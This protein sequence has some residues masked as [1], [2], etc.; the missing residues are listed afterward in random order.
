MK[1]NHIVVPYNNMSPGI[2]FQIFN[3]FFD[4]LLNGRAN[5]VVETWRLGTEPRLLIN[6]PLDDFLSR[7]KFREPNHWL[8]K[9]LALGILS[10]FDVSVEAE[11]Q[12][13]DVL[14]SYCNK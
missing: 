13:D 10:L 11:V 4:V 9:L 14:R 6:V 7:L 12:N 2:F 8:A 5:D 1:F 3:R